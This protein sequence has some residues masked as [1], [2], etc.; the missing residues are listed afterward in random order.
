MAVVA[1]FPMMVKRDRAAAAKVAA[2]ETMMGKA[3]L[4]TIGKNLATASL[5]TV[6]VFPT[7]TVEIMVVG[8]VAEVVVPPVGVAA[9]VVV[10]VAVNM[11]SLLGNAGNSVRVA[12]APM[13]RTADS[14]TVKRTTE[15]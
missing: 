14:A 13:V 5:G 15:I 4:A 6:A 1:V 12:T 7:G 11:T 3:I 8:M 2:A 9:V 10:V